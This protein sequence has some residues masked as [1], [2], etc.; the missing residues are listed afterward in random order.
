[1]DTKICAGKQQVA[2]THPTAIIITY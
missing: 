1:M 2:P